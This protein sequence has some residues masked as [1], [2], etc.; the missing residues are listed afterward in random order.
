ME[1]NTVGIE[2]EHT[3]LK[4]KAD[5]ERFFLCIFYESKITGFKFEKYDFTKS[6]FLI[7]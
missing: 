7:S 3:I 6:N 5:K 4:K 2:N 1:I